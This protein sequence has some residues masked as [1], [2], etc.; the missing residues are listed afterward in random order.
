MDDREGMQR[1]QS[2]FKILIGNHSIVRIELWIFTYW[3]SREKIYRNYVRLE[4]CYITQ[5]DSGDFLH[6]ISILFGNDSGLVIKNL[7]VG[8]ENASYKAQFFFFS[9]KSKNK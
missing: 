1:T 2:P 5:V 7:A 8:N 4:N 9:C 3:L 6:L